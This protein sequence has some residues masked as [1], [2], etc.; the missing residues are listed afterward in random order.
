M[1]LAVFLVSV[2]AA[3]AEPRK[4]FFP[5]NQ[6]LQFSMQS[7][8]RTWGDCAGKPCVTLRVR[9]PAFA[10]GPGVRPGDTLNVFVQETLLGKYD[11]RGVAPVL[12]AVRDSVAGQF[13]ALP[14]SAPPRPWTIERNISVL[15][16]TLG[17]MTLDVEEFRETGGAHPTTM[18][19]LY[20]IRP[21]TMQVLGLDDIVPREHKLHLLDLCERAFRKARKLLPDKSLADAG[22]TFPGGKFAL[23]MNVGLTEK[24][25]L[26]F[27]NPY[28]IA[29]YVM[30]PTKVIVEWKDINGLLNL[31]N[32]GR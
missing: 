2:V 26:F 14:G 27:Y 10:G 24:G 21:A 8:E 16:D 32:P 4:P 18:H 20:M 15:G 11:P 9:Y 1:M 29:P 22:F 17:V 7:L 28:E 6:R 3:V 19:L 23:T 30:G 25:L 5:K 13:R 12:E 31:G